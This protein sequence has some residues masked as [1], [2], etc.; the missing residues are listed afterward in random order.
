M[1]DISGLALPS[2]FIVGGMSP[3][4]PGDHRRAN[5]H[6]RRR[7]QAQDYAES[8]VAASHDEHCCAL[9]HIAECEDCRF[10]LFKLFTASMN[11]AGAIVIYPGSEAS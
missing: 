7:A 3:L 4:Q 1:P 5:R 11:E 6:N 10:Q 8:F 9:A 2:S